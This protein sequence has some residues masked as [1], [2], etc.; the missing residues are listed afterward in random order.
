MTERRKVLSAYVGQVNTPETDALAAVPHIV[1]GHTGDRAWAV[2]V[3]AACPMTAIDRVRSMPDAEF[4]MLQHVPTE[5]HRF[6]QLTAL[7]AIGR[8]VDAA[9][10]DLG[11]E[12][13]DLLLSLVDR[14]LDHSREGEVAVIP[15]AAA[16]VA[17]RARI[18][19]EEDHP[20]LR[21]LNGLSTMAHDIRRI[22]HGT[23]DETLNLTTGTM[24]TL[25]RGAR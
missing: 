4:H 21:S 3:T 1:R 20:A 8:I 16:L 5:T 2:V 13:R 11:Y 17:V 15:Q 10:D 22:V 14:G 7:Q 6:S 23:L 19:G 12:Q 25:S 9:E 18:D 24:G